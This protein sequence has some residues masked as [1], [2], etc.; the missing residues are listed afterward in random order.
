MGAVARG[1]GCRPGCSLGNGRV[2]AIAGLSRAPNLKLLM[3]ALGRDAANRHFTVRDIVDD[4][5]MEPNLSL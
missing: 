4:Q 3:S 1:A 2:L 5:G